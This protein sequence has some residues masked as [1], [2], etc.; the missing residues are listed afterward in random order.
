MLHIKFDFAEPIIAF[1]HVPN[2]IFVSG[3]REMSVIN[4]FYADGIIRLLKSEGVSCKK[5]A[6]SEGYVKIKL[7]GAYDF[8]YDGIDVNEIIVVKGNNIIYAFDEL[9]NVIDYDSH[10]C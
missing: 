1:Q 2:R 4:D 7:S 8:M 6:R 3:N 5:L 9:G 10:Q